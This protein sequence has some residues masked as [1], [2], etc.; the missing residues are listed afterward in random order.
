[1]GGSVIATELSDRHSEEEDATA[2]Q[3][4]PTPGNHWARGWLLTGEAALG[5]GWA[6]ILSLQVRFQ[7][8]SMK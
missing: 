8:K 4:E 6:G 1:M 5:P 3:L 7:G 2:T